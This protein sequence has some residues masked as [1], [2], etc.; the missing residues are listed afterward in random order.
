M[1]LAAPAL[2]TGAARVGL[3]MCAHAMMTTLRWHMMLGG[4][5]LRDV[6]IW[7][8]S[9]A[10]RR[11]FQDVAEEVFGFGDTLGLGTHDL[12][13]P[14]EGNILPSPEA[15]TFLDPRLVSTQRR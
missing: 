13:L 12:G 3:E 15:A 14:V 11:A 2:G 1:S 5:R 9:D 8:D 10:K 6:T 7:L 4:T